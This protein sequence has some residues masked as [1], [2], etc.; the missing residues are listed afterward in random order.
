MASAD[1]AQS[2]EDIITL[3]LKAADRHRNN[4]DKVGACSM[5]EFVYALLSYGDDEMSSDPEMEVSSFGT[6]DLDQF[7]RDPAGRF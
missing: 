4:G 3:L 2:T 1:A 5:I 7:V 6:P